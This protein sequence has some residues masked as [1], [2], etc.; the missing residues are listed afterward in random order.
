MAGLGTT[1]EAAKYFFNSLSEDKAKYYEEIMTASPILQTVLEN[2]AYAALPCVYLVTEDDLAVPAAYQEGMVA[3]Q[4]MREGVDIKIVRCPSGHSPFL[5][6]TEGLVAELLS[7]GKA[8][9]VYSC[10]PSW[11]C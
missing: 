4:N 8:V 9:L 7:F 5:T 10:N 3:L 1:T 6:W 2:D 11:R